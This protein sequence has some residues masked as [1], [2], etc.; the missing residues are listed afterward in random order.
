M[1]VRDTSVQAF[2]ENLARGI[3]G[4]QKVAVSALVKITGPGYRRQLADR[5]GFEMGAICGAV[6]AL[7][8]DNILRDPQVVISA[9]TKRPVHLVELVAPAPVQETLF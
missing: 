4:T 3:Y 7:I 1:T 9:E 2:R 6:N 5:S 8:K